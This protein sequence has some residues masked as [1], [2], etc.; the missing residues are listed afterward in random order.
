MPGK[1]DV[2][3]KIGGAASRWENII[4]RSLKKVQCQGWDELGWKYYKTVAALCYMA[5]NRSGNERLFESLQTYKEKK[6]PHHR[7][8]LSSFLKT[9]LNR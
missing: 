6:S 5:I 1:P 4:L 2:K 7:D 8:K 9:R 3:G